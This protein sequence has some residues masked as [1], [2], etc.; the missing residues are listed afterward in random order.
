MYNRRESEQR[1]ELD[2]VVRI[3]HL[4]VFS[5]IPY[6]TFVSFAIDRRD[7]SHTR[8][9]DLLDPMSACINTIYRQMQ[10]TG[11]PEARSEHY[12]SRC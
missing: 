7:S 11:S 5:F 10:R 8:F 1:K 12:S 9:F 4:I 3:H 2:V 6:L